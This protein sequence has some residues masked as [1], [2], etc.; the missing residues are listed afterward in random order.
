LITGDKPEERAQA[1]K[2]R[3]ISLNRAFN[4]SYAN[5]KH[6]VIITD[7]AVPLL[8]TGHQAVAAWHIWYKGTLISEDWRARGLALSDDAETQA[9]AG[10]F[11][12][13]ANLV[14]LSDLEEIHV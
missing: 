10:A 4:R 6:A 5:S 13:L 14:N 1:R 9:I 3:L 8:S 2:T 11:T 12:T 7:A